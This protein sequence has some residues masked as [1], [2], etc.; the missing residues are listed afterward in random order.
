[1]HFSYFFN[2]LELNA[3]RRVDGQASS[4]III[5]SRSHITPIVAISKPTTGILKEYS[6]NIEKE[7]VKKHGKLID[8]SEWSFQIERKTVIAHNQSEKI[9]LNLKSDE[10]WRFPRII[11]QNRKKF[12][13]AQPVAQ[14]GQTKIQRLYAQVIISS[15][16]IEIILIISYTMTEVKGE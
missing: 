6:A 10:T 15:I 8:G 12:L 9:R 1:M 16:K 5:H 11:P 14:G 13:K 7:V 3:F 4:S 2:D